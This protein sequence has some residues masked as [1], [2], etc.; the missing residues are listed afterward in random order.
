[1]KKFFYSENLSKTQ[2]SGILN[3]AKIFAKKHPEMS[4][5]DLV[6]EFFDELFYLQKIGDAKFES[7]DLEDERL[8]K[9][10]KN[11]MRECALKAAYKE[12]NKEFFAK[13]KEYMREAR[14]KAAIY[15]AE[16]EKPTSKQVIY[17]KSLCRK[18]GIEPETAENLSKADYMRMISD[19]LGTTDARSHEAENPS[20]E[21]FPPDFNEKTYDTARNT[22][23]S[24][25]D[26]PDFAGGE[27]SEPPKGCSEAANAVFTGSFGGHG[28]PPVH[29]SPEAKIPSPR[30][31]SPDKGFDTVCEIDCRFLNDEC[32]HETEFPS[33]QGFPPVSDDG[34]AACANRSRTSDSG[35]VAEVSRNPDLTRDL[36]INPDFKKIRQSLVSEYT[37][38]KIPF[39]T[40]IAELDFALEAVACISP[41]DFILGKTP[42]DEQIKTLKNAVATRLSTGMPMQLVV[43]TAYFAGSR[44]FVDE[45]VLVPRPETEL[46]VE[47][48]L[49]FMYGKKDLKVL[50]IG[51]GS[52]CIAVSLAKMT[53]NA[54]FT[55][56]DISP[57]AL[58]VARK[59]AEN[60]GVLPKIDFVL[61]NVFE[62][63]SEKFDIIVSNPPYIPFDAD[64][65][66]KNVSSF[67]PH[68]ALF[69]PEN[70]L[71]FYRTIVEN[72]R[73]YLNDDGLV[74]FEVGVDQS[75]KVAEL[76][77]END[78]VEISEISDLQGIPRVVSAVLKSSE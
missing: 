65:V 67:E 11:V 68:T 35:M 18:A 17:Y 25:K 2:L 4:C 47:K 58:D 39:R 40:A 72:A 21:G 42:S 33:S 20:H 32:S 12:R 63:I 62:N 59:N 56:V 37:K 1:M 51:T 78:F 60:I 41:K 3:S 28:E 19:M 49:E 5:D 46:C 13:R 31:F 8:F 44:F 27:R 43:N 77:A 6:S 48:C 57:K 29:P 64:N 9:D 10:V 15:R 71:F 16:R 36:H 50:D 52:G 54:R 76:F 73:K 38:N 14:K 7:I 74:V 75:K 55:A 45:N 22:F 61:S 66:D 26:L 34:H 53:E 69:A 23:F 70:G 24:S 30:G